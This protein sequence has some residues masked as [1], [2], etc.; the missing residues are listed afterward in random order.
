[1][2]EATDLKA[3]LENE[4]NEPKVYL[5]LLG[6]GAQFDDV[7]QKATQV[8]QT[9][10]PALYRL[11]RVQDRQQLLAEEQELGDLVSAGNAAVDAVVLGP[12][13][14][15][16]RQKLTFPITAIDDGVKITNAFAQGAQ[17]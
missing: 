6:E 10:S 1:M 7:A 3:Q 14:G 8:I 12:G 11:F 5:I 15:L 2:S 4:H 17:L 9:V 13:E 16:D